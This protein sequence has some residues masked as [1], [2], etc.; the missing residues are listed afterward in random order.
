MMIVICN[1]NEENVNV[2]F[3]CA[4]VIPFTQQRKKYPCVHKKDVTL[5]L[6]TAGG[7][8]GK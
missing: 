4:V 3:L 2:L 8:G 6:E 1:S 5:T 7:G